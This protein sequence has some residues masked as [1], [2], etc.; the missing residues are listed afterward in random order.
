M[1][2]I[3]RSIIIYT[4]ALY[5]L[6]Y[7]VTGVVI[8]RDIFTLLFAGIVLTLMMFTIKPILDVISFPFNLLTM[9][10]FSIF[11]NAVI[12]YLLTVFVNGI[13]IKAYR[14]GGAEIAGFI[15][16]AISFNTLFAFLAAAFV[17]SL[18]VTTMKWL[19][20]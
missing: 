15:I 17:L 20:E 18:I 5:V 7:V 13:I 14:F 16:P 11:T 8:S 6:P 3:A 1:K 10:L 19:T 4:L 12:L 2:L 9:G